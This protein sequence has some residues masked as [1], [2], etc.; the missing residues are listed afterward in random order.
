MFCVDSVYICV[1][2]GFSG[3][4]TGISGQEESSGMC[5]VH[6]RLSSLCVHTRVCVCMCVCGGG[7]CP[8]EGFVSA[9]IRECLAVS[10]PLCLC[11]FLSLGV[12]ASGVCMCCICRCHGPDPQLM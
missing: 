7:V 9:L 12:Y 4:T 11:V 10:R 5:A 2:G 3:R 6:Q 8:R 1:C